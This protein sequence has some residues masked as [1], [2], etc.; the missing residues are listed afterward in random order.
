[1]K[2]SYV[3]QERHSASQPC[4]QKLPLRFLVGPGDEMGRV[5][6]FVEAVAPPICTTRTAPDPAQ[7]VTNW[8]LP[9]F[10]EPRKF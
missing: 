1:M 9:E 7:I 3:L 5:G 10:G 2:W 8:L 4:R 6:F